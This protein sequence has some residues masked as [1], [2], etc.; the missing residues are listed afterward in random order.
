M[1]LRVL[2]VEDPSHRRRHGSEQSQ[3]APDENTSL[4]ASQAR[5]PGDDEHAHPDETDDETRHL[6]PRQAFAQPDASHDAGRH[7]DRR[8]EERLHAC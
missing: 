8:D 1:K 5:L 7:R 3:R 6:G 2:S 4:T